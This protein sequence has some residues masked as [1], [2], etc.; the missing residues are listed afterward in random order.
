MSYFRKIG[1]G[2]SPKSATYDV[3]GNV[4]FYKHIYLA[5]DVEHLPDAVLF[6]FYLTRPKVKQKQ[7]KLKRNKAIQIKNFNNSNNNNKKRNNTKEIKA[8]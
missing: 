1:R 7:S 5:C 3:T 6:S 8:C 2:L 4:S